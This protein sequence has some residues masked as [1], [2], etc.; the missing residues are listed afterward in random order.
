MN[1]PTLGIGATNPIAVWW[2]DQVVASVD[3]VRVVDR[4]RAETPWSGRYAFM[5]LMSAGIAVLGLLLSSPAV[6]IGAML[7][8]P[9]MG[10]IIGL[11]FG[12][13]T[14]DWPEIRAA[15]LALALGVL[16]AVGFTG[17]IVLLSPIQNVTTEIAARTRP[18][19]FDLMV[20][21]F[22]ALA[23]AYAMVRG[24][25]GTVV[26]VAIA[27]ALMPPLAVVGFGLA[28][29]NWTVF[30]GSLLLFFT[31]LMTIA[32][33]AAVVA[34]LYGFGS[35]LSPQH[36]LYQT[37]VVI[38]VLVAL[39]APLAVALRQIAWESIFSRQAREVMAA[40]FG[41]EAR[42]SQL[43]IDYE[44]DP[45]RV[46]ATV[47][48]P[49][50]HP[51]AETV[52]SQILRERTDRAV[53][54]AI[55]QYRVEAG[56]QAEAA[57]IANAQAG[58]N[59]ADRA[60]TRLAEQLALVA[61]VPRSAIAIDRDERR[62]VVRAQPL[63]GAGLAAYRVLEQR[64]SAQIAGWRVELIPPAAPLPTIAFEGDAPTPAG[65][66]A[67]SLA[68]WAA[69]R[70]GTPVVAT[71]ASAAAEAV[72]AALSDAGVPARVEAGGNAGGVALNWSAPLAVAPEG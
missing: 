66:E 16:L 44:R 59:A 68:A 58:P 67:L 38:G 17:A 32:V 72:V 54:V 28:T 37:I 50:F 8:S 20:A 23:G 35:H 62:A 26:G 2:R 40:E 42:V 49:S 30:G 71:G 25:E 11:G 33:A 12:L 22:S 56:S 9:L 64:V 3:H 13:A 34:R 36:T 6:V 47:L 61:G 43:E 1:Q 46:T 4:V 52:T 55:E 60:A 31:N 65:R 21:L 63:P 14:F 41:D 45:I 18:N 57:Q 7:I 48:T 39:A 53:D 27:T 70:T 69:Q 51:D 10:P 29:A 24:R 15:S 5:T 19:L